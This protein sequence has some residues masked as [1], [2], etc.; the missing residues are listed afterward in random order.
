MVQIKK[1]TLTKQKLMNCDRGAVVLRLY[2]FSI[3][4]A[5]DWFVWKVILVRV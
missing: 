2:R 1:R 5:F 4:I 3:S